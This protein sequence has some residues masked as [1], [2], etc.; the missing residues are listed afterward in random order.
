MTGAFM[1]FL[2]PCL[3][4]ALVFSLL[5]VALWALR[6]HGAVQ[7]RAPKSPAPRD[8]LQLRGKLMLTAQH[9][10]HC[11]RVGQREFVLGVH[12]SGI[13]FLGEVC[14]DAAGEVLK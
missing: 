6:N 4:I 5:W 2:R 7:F 1:E 3:A 14:P 8:L 9:S 10:V 11:V 13:T 12:P